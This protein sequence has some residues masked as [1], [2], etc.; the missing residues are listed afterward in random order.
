MYT[1]IYIY[2]NTFTPIQKDSV[3][4]SPSI[5]FLGATALNLFPQGFLLVL[6]VYFH[7][8]QQWPNQR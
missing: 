1:N 4:L 2:F 6:V 7:G 8:G 5:F 3:N